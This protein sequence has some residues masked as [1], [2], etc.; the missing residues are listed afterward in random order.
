MPMRKKQTSEPK[1]KL[2]L[3]ECLSSLSKKDDSDGLAALIRSINERGR[4]NKAKAKAKSKSKAIV[5]HPWQPE[6][7]PPLAA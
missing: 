6:P 3:I 4:L 2:T 7:E 1:L 5:E